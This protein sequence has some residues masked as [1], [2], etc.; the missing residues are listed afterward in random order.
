MHVAHLPLA[1]FDELIKNTFPGIVAWLW[2]KPRLHGMG[3]AK[4]I[5]K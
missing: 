5:R 2:G 3:K 4:M 1:F